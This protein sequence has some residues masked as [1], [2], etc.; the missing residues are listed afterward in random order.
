MAFFGGLLIVAFIALGIFGGM[1]AY[2][3][4]VRGYQ[5]WFIFEPLP[6]MYFGV[7]LL[8]TLL[9]SIAGFRE[10][11]AWNGSLL[12]LAIACFPFGFIGAVM[13]IFALGMESGAKMMSESFTPHPRTFDRGDGAMAR[14][15]YADAERE[16]RTAVELEP[17]DNEALMRLIRALEAQGQVKQAAEELSA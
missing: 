10:Y 2:S 7:A 6:A 3:R 16:Y 17:H 15:K 9:G 11:N 14:G 5:G 1:C 13:W 4:W 12:L 8:V